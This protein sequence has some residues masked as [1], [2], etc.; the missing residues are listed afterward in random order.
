[1][2]HGDETHVVVVQRMSRHAV[3]QGRIGGTGLSRGA[4]QVILSLAVNHA[5]DDTRSRLDGSG[6]DYTGRVANRCSSP[7]PR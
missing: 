2:R 1:M 4:E 3:R 6:E 7:L 5:A